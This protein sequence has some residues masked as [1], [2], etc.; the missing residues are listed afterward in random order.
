MDFILQVS[1]IAN[2]FLLQSGDKQINLCQL[3][4]SYSCSHG[5]L[6]HKCFILHDQ[7]KLIVLHLIIQYFHSTSTVQQ[8]PSIEAV[9]LSSFPSKRTSYFQ[10]YSHLPPVYQE[11]V[12]QKRQP[13]NVIPFCAIDFQ[14][15]SRSS[16]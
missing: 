5:E 1:I 7:V 12:K 15:H 3:N 13:G 4:A 11:W 16:L 8:G 10:H 6:D 2:D 14:Q 9:F